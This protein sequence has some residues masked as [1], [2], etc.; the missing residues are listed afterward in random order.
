MPFFIFQSLLE[1]LH[2]LERESSRSDSSERGRRSGRPRAPP[3]MMTP[4]DQFIQSLLANLIGGRGGMPPG[5]IHIATTSGGGGMPGFFTLGSGPGGGPVPMMPLYGNPGDYAWGR[6]GLDAIVTQLLNQMEGTGPPPMNDDEI[7]KIPTI[8]IDQSHI[9][10][11]FIKVLRN[12][13]TK[14]IAKS[15]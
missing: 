9:G 7:K 5:S 11:D 6:G 2:G 1:G 4:S 10:K 8:K 14:M 13:N 15:T 3:H 12:R